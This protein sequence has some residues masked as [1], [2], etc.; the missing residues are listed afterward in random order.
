MFCILYVYKIWENLVFEM[1][2][3]L[4]VGKGFGGCFE[5]LIKYRVIKILVGFLDLR[6]ILYGENKIFK[7]RWFFL[8]L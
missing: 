3:L 6:G 2:G 1:K 8:F 5:V 7:V 4:V